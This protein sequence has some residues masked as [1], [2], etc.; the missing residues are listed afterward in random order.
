MSHNVIQPVGVVMQKNTYPKDWVPELAPSILEA[1]SGPEE[2][3]QCYDRERRSREKSKHD[4]VIKEQFRMSSSTVSDWDRREDPP[5]TDKEKL[6]WFDPGG[7]IKS[8]ELPSCLYG[9]FRINQAKWPNPEKEAS[10]HSS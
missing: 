2:C 9:A 5:K 7:V 8:Q 4:A 1:I 6:M 10:F 3:D